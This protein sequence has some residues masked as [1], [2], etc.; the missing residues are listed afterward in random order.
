[1]DRPM[2]S[3]HVSVF[4]FLLNKECPEF[5]AAAARNSVLIPPSCS[6]QPIHY[7]KL[8]TP[9]HAHKIINMNLYIHIYMNIMVRNIG[10]VITQMHFL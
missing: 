2:D 6:L 10:M 3:L 7:N 1:M 9:F 8:A 5:S 4:Y